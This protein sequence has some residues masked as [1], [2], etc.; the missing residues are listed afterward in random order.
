[1][2]RHT[3]GAGVI[4]PAADEDKAF[5]RCERELMPKSSSV[6]ACQLAERKTLRVEQGN[7]L[8][9]NDLGHGGSDH[10]PNS[11]R[12]CF[13]SFTLF[14]R[15]PPQP[16]LLRLWLIMSILRIK[17]ASF[18]GLKNPLFD[19]KLGLNFTSALHRIC[20]KWRDE[21]RNFTPPGKQE[22]PCAGTVP[23][24]AWWRWSAPQKLNQEL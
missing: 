13:F 14:F 5:S 4:H 24:S 8:P 22:N 12:T 11:M 23:T 16:S 20:V 2:S 17:N 15:I 19:V 3:H 10:P 6:R 7:L 9:I 21:S 1:M 18:S